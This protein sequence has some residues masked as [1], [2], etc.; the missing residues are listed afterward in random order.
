MAVLSP[1]IPSSEKV[2]Y[3]FYDIETTQDTPYSTN[4]FLHVPNLICVQQ[5]CTKCQHV[6][7][8]NIPCDHCGT[9]KHSFWDTP[10]KAFIDY[11][12][13]PRDKINK[14][15]A[16]AHNAKSFDLQFILNYMISL[17]WTPNILLN[18]TKIVCMRVHHIVFLDSLNYLPMPLRDLPKAFG[19]PAEKGHYPH[20]FNTSTNLNYVG[21]YPDVSYYGVDTMRARDRAEFLAW[22]EQRRHEVFDNKHSLESYCQSDVTVLRLACKTF[23]SLFRSI[24]NLEV[25]LESVSIASACNKVFRRNFLTADTIGIIPPGGYTDGRVQSRKAM[26]WL[27]YEQI[28][29]GTIRI[30]HGRNGKEYRLPELP[31]YSVDGYCADTKTVYEFMGCFWHGHTCLSFRDVPICNSEETLADRYEKTMS[32]LE[33]ITEAGYKVK[34]MWECD[35]DKILEGHPALKLHPLVQVG[36]LRTRDALYGGRTEALKLHYKVNPEEETIQYTDIMSLY[37][38][39]CK[40]FKFPVGHPTILNADECRDINAILAKEGIIKCEVLPPQNLYHPVLP[41]RSPSGRLLFPLCRTCALESLAECT[42][43]GSERALVGTWIVDEIRKA[44]DMGYQVVTIYEFYEYRI[45][46]YNPLTGEGGHFVDYINTFLKLKVE[47]SGY[48][49]HVLTEEDTDKYV[50]DFFH[51]DG[52]TVDKQSIAKNAAKRGLSKLC[53]N[54]FWGKLT[55]CNNRPKSTLIT[56]PNELYRFLSTPG[57]EVTN[58][59]FASDEVV[60]ISWRFREEEIVESLPHTNE[61]IGAYVT[62][63]ARLKLYSYLEKLGTSALYCDTDSVIYVAARNEPPPIECGDKLGDM[64]NELGSGEYIDEFVSGGPKN[65]AYKIVQSDGNT[66]TVCK[67]RGITLNY[68]TSQIVNFETIRDMILNREEHQ[69][70][71]H[72]DKKI[73]RKRTFGGPSVISQPEDKRYTITFL[74]RRRLDNNDSLPFG[75]V[76]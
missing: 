4:A 38:Y 56:D 63:G 68:T 69:V 52:I 8:I 28:S 75:F 50:S 67:V 57:I 48:P 22:Y 19:L 71:V 20:F 65:Y 49:D 37:P 55:E 34:V 60:W 23:R 9:R 62:T 61:V 72:S 21:A 33:R 54:S 26:M 5:F 39:I 15:I 27:V 73:K 45:T 30:R 1:Q 44:V 17:K 2:L 74:K 10:V 70:V 32:R 59:L 35:F 3:V 66:R 24:G 47:A 64:T 31:H 11:L 29:D 6:D 53:L 76:S 25:F 40:Y 43:G 42:H 13:T 18:G 51:S 16:I 36:P 12:C 14:I 41:Y 58:L 7:D 46:Q